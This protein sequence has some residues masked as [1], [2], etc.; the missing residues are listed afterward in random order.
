MF[1]QVGN[2]SDNERQCDISGTLTK[3]YI[4][5]GSNKITIENLIVKRRAN[6]IQGE[7][8]DCKKLL[9]SEEEYPGLYDKLTFFARVFIDDFYRRF[10]N[11]GLYIDNIYFKD[12]LDFK[13]IAKDYVDEIFKVEIVLNIIENDFTGKEKQNIKIICEWNFLKSTI[14]IYIK[15]FDY[16]IIGDEIFCELQEDKSFN[17][18]E[19]SKAAHRV[20]GSSLRKDIKIN[21]SEDGAK[22]L[23]RFI[24]NYF[25]FRSRFE[26]KI[27]QRRLDLIEK[28]EQQ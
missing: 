27:S 24:K 10:A 3:R 22:Q 13:G 12:L 26:Q 9:L 16:G 28:N 25:I 11:T 4:M 8:L 1:W 23:N 15:L 7:S 20:L 6:Y 14:S 19:F 21:S 17:I 5:Q 2:G 18:F